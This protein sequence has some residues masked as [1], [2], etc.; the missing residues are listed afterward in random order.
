M[1]FSQQLPNVFAR[2][3]RYNEEA[4]KAS[5]NNDDE[6]SCEVISIPLLVFD[7]VTKKVNMRPHV[8]TINRTRIRSFS[9]IL[10]VWH[11]EIIWFHSFLVHFPMFHTSLHNLVVRY[12]VRLQTILWRWWQRWRPQLANH[13]KPIEAK[14]NQLIRQCLINER[15]QTWMIQFSDTK[16]QTF[17]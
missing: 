10:R 13:W 1:S 12:T 16:R 6:V 4:S 14:N 8:N 11:R 9:R 17:Y 7:V 5:D 15:S 2:A 3:Y